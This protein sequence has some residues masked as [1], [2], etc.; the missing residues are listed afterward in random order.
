MYEHFQKDGQTSVTADL[1]LHMLVF[2][3]SIVQYFVQK[4]L[5]FY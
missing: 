1:L 4:T 2:F 3:L 5:G